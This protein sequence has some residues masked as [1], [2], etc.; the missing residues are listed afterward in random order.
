[1]DFIVLTKFLYNHLERKLSSETSVFSYSIVPPQLVLSDCVNSTQD[2]SQYRENKKSFRRA[3]PEIFATC[4][5]TSFHITVGVT[6]A[7]TSSLM[8]QLEE[9][10][11]D[12]KAT[13]PDLAWI[14]S[15][16][17]IVLP[18]TS[19]LAG[20]LM[21][22]F[23][24]LNAVKMSTIP[25][26]ISCVIIALASDVYMIIGGRFLFGIAAALGTNPAI[27]YVTEITSPEYRGALISSGPTLTSLG[28]GK[29]SFWRKFSG[30]KK[31][32]GY[33][34]MIIMIIFF[35]FQQY[36]G[37]Y[38]TIFYI[39]QYFEAAGSKMN[40]FHASILVGLTRFVMSMVTV[41]LLK[42]FGRRP[43]CITS[44]IG[45]GTFA[46][47]SGYY[48]HQVILSGESSIMPV[49]TIMLYV[50]FSMIGLLSL[51]WTMAAE[52]FPTEIRGIAHGLVIGTVH[53]IM[54]LSLQTYY[55]MADFFGGHDGLQWFF[56]FMCVIALVFIY[57]F[58]PETH[59]KSLLEIEN[60]F[61][62]HTIYRKSNDEDDDGY[63]S[64]SRG[65]QENNN[66]NLKT[67]E[68]LLEN[69][70]EYDTLIVKT[71]KLY[72]R[73]PT[74]EESMIGDTSII[75]FSSFSEV[76][77]YDRIQSSAGTILSV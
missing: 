43:L 46:T 64:N 54:F 28:I 66:K 45:M 41:Y 67:M 37:V 12:I 29:P 70:A 75:S 72:P 73:I 59:G 5:A 57:F 38:I 20:I 25:A 76:M 49:F 50:A 65:N 53:A 13:K 56:A 55:D 23:G 77:L 34:P 8:P 69:Q 11:S 51:P 26:I 63:K 14:A 27:V 17:F 32:T 39:V 3:L 21:E 22:S 15:I 60:Y 58:L 1:M 48:T 9:P 6:F 7:S 24:R 18:V 4:S 31:P 52:V 68:T 42:R 71:D 47:I 33:K 19:V 40:P 74:E 44:C 16:I 10:D 2:L 35:F 30:L 36:T 61:I 62:R